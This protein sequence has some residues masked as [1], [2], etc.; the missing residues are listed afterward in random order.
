MNLLNLLNHI[1]WLAVIIVTVISFPLGAYWHS[2]KMFGKA[3][4]ED[5][6]PKFDSSKKSSF[7]VLFGLSAVLHFFAITGLAL[8]LGSNSNAVSGFYLGLAVGIFWV[9]TTIS[10]THLFAGRSIRLIL[11]DTGFYIVYFSIAGLILGAWH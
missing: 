5:A 1:N 4:N 3:W 8:L 11:I 9:V 10:V 2:K 7:I 6:Q